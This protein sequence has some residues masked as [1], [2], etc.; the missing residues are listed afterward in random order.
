VMKFCLGVE[1]IGDV[2]THANLMKIGSGVLEGAGVKFPTFPLTY[3]VVLYTLRHYRA[4]ML[5]VT[6]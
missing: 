6:W 2:I 4:S 3:A 1:V 5:C